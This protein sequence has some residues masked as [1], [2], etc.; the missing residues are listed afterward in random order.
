MRELNLSSYTR[1]II[2]KV[3]AIAFFINSLDSMILNIAIPT[4][5]RSLQVSPLELKLAVTSY[6]LSQGVFIPVSG[7]LA[8]RFGTRKIFMLSVALFGLGS[9]AS[10]FS[11]SLYQLVLARLLQGVGGAMMLPVGR[12]ALNKIYPK[13]EIF[14]IMATV[15]TISLLGPALGPIFGG[16][17]VS[18]FSWRWIFFINI[19]FVITG[20]ILI[21]KYMPNLV[22]HE[23][24]R[25]DWLGF[26]LFGMGVAG[27]AFAFSIIGSEALPFS[28]EFIFLLIG[29]VCFG[30]YYLHHKRKINPFINTAVFKIR[31]YRIALICSANIRLGTSAL[32]FLLALMY[33]LT[34]HLSAMKTAILLLP[35][36]LGML[37]TKVLA[38]AVVNRL[39]LKQTMLYNTVIL[40]FVIISFCFI[41]P[42]DHKLLIVISLFIFGYSISLQYTSLQ[43]L[44]IIDATPTLLGQMISLAAALQQVM[45]SVSVAFSALLLQIFLL[46]H[47]HVEFSA[48]AFHST[49]IVIAAVILMSYYHIA[50]LHHDDGQSVTGHKSKRK[51]VVDQ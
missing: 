25:L 43:T 50:K 39:G 42:I 3:V 30:L 31:T 17:I 33:Q 20:L 13:S 1:K 47:R 23:V 5:A 46:R 40:A 26:L 45:G 35:Y 24:E 22:N 34:Y 44:N 2:P 14:K 15:G 9:L 51:L 11:F 19:P 10:G 36:P 41:Q 48:H 7:W 21:N 28:N 49:F 12:I 6:L 18:Y 29:V 8:D 27:V 38:T 4:I 37:V 32:S 16:L